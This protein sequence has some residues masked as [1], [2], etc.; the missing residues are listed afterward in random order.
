MKQRILFKTLW[1]HISKKQIT[2]IVGARQTG[3]TTLMQQIYTRLKREKKQ[4]FFISMEDPNI[5]E[6]L[7]QHPDNLFK[8]LPP[9]SNNGKIIL[10]FDEIQYLKN[11]TNF[12]KYHYDLNQDTIKIIASG[13]SAFYVNKNFK[14]S[15]AGR[16]RIFILPTLSFEEFLIFKNREEIV[17]Y[18]NSGSI[19]QIYKSELKKWLNEYLL[20]GGYPEIVI[21]RN[22]EEKKLLLKELADSYIKKDILDANISYPDIYLK[23]M[24][25]LSQNKGLFNSNNIS[26]QLKI[27]CQT[28][29]AYL[30]LMETSFHITKILP[31]HNNIE[32]ELRKMPKYYFNDLGLRNYFFKNYESIFLREDRGN[33]LENFVFRRFYDFYPVEDIRFW[34]TQKKQEVDFI[35]EEK[36]AYEVKFSSKN[37]NQQKYYY[38]KK[39]YPDIPLSLIDIDNVLELKL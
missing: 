22:L 17:S 3:K 7:D 12:L 31:F 16:K 34:R 23:I 25:I 26:K 14:D 20:F 6:T 39:K 15:L 21:E 13:S 4:T 11:P 5:L 1:K 24:K 27:G 38:F 32:K 36:K 33:L 37:Y 18:I 29:N 19:T 8:I 2:L 28:V 30:K 9:L 35:I 10:F